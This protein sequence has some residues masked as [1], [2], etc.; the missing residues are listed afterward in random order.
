MASRHPEG[1]DGLRSE[2]TRLAEAAGRGD[3]ASLDRMRQL[4]WQEAE[5]VTLE[6]ALNIVA[7]SEGF[8]DWARLV[9][10]TDRHGLDRARQV[11]ELI[12]A[13]YFGQDWRVS[14]LL[15]ADPDAADADFGVQCALFRAQKVRSALKADPSLATRQ[16]GPRPPL[17]HV[18]FSRHGAGARDVQAA[19]VEVAA[20]LAEAGADVNDWM[21]AWQGSEHRLSMLYGAIGHAGN[22]PLGRWLLDKG[23]DPNDGE[24][25]YHATELGHHDGLR[26]LLAAGADPRGTNAL[27]RAMDFDDVAAARMLLDAGARADDFD[28]R[29]IGG[30]S[31][32]VVPALHQAARRHCSAEMV[33]LLL[34]AGADPNRRHDGCTAYAF[35]RVFGNAAL[36]AALEAQGADTTLTAEEALLAAAA[37]GRDTSGRYVD[38]S[39][40]PGSYRNIL[41]TLLHLPDVHA[42]LNR[43]VAIGIE[44]DRPDAEGVTPVQGAGWSGLPDVMAWFLRLGP[45]LSHVNGYGGTLLGTIVHGSE[46]SPHRAHRD[47]VACARLALEHG[48]ALPRDMPRLAGAR[49]MAEFLTAWA[50]AHPGQVV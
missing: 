12:R 42:H 7:R 41:G 34:E 13:L 1:L 25:L 46:N 35:A 17:A 15:A 36:A 31:P 39:R 18:C 3:A 23:A 38:P 44:W 4:G 21:P 26:M 9:D 28:D 5:G 33:T 20:L 32:W 19:S 45:D 50:E 49:P 14:E 37:D 16:D 43:L 22:M 11:Q 2:A 48:V 40:L 10:L 8:A 24:S 6:A 47:H 27:L 30:E 29:E